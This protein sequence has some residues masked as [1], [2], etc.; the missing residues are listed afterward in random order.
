MFSQLAKHV[1]RSCQIVG[2]QLSHPLSNR[3]TPTVPILRSFGSRLISTYYIFCS[4][5]TISNDVSLG[6]SKKVKDLTF[7]LDLDPKTSSSIKDP[8]L[9]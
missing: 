3:A 4:L 1:N 7:L 9:D 5:P 6:R 8:E 2:K